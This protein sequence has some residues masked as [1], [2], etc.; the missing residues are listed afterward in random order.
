MFYIG[1]T[2]G[3]RTD[4]DGWHHAEG[5]LTLGEAREG[6]RSDLGTWSMRDYE[7]HWRDAVSRLLSGKPCSVLITSYRGPGADYHFAWPMWRDGQA[8]YVQERLLFAEPLPRPFDPAAAWDLVGER[9]MMGEDG[10]HISEWRVPLGHLAA[11]L[12]DE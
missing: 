4:E 3:A 8:V 9:V 1:F 12:L 11:Y 2:T 6:F 7:A 10:E 5:E